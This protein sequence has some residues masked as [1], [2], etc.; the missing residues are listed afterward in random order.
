[1]RKSVIGILGAAVVALGT[2]AAPAFAQEH[3]TLKSAKTTS[4][5]YMMMVQLS[6][7]MKASSDGKIL[8]TV[9]E[10]QGSVQNVK[11]SFARPGNFLFTTP[12]ILLAKAR[13]GQ[14]PFKGKPNDTART[15]F[16]MPF[17][18]VHFVVKAD[19]KIKSVSDLAG[20]TFLA[21]GKGTFCQGASMAIMSTLGVK[22]SVDIVDIE[23]SSANSAMRNGKIDGFSTCSAYPTPQ[24][25]EL[26]T[27]SNVRVLSFSKEELDS[28]I[29]KH[30]KYTRMTIPANTY[31]DQTKE[32]KTLTMAVGAYGTEK[33]SD[34]VAYTTTKTFWEWKDKLAKESSWWSGVT[35]P[36]VGDLGAKLHPGAA[37]YYKEAGVEIPADMM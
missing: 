17:L 28:I 27:T 15:L 20:A 6:E 11:E 25:I 10:S 5:Y 2:T 32:I 8:P 18:T 26:A 21:G 16:P 19:S 35:K 36:L 3:L 1:M 4:S 34:N 24:V 12:P 30:P 7:M 9:E 13:A 33:M 29:A 31:K 23:I 37:K 14:K 22:D